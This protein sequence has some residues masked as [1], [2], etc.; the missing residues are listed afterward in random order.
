MSKDL[1]KKY[2]IQTKTKEKSEMFFKF[3]FGWGGGLRV[4]KVSMVGVIHRKSQ[5]TTM[6]WAGV[7]MR[8]MMVGHAS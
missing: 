7:P 5:M 8:G 3:L 2:V 1:L 4:Q 6:T